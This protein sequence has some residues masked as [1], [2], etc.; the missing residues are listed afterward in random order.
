MNKNS[1]HHPHPFLAALDHDLFD[2]SLRST[3]NNGS[4]CVSFPNLNYRL[5]PLTCYLQF[6]P[7]SR[8]P[9]CTR[10]LPLR[11][12]SSSSNG[13]VAL[14]RGFLFDKPHQRANC[15]F[16]INPFASRLLSFLVIQLR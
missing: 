16:G 13:K 9:Y 12:R 5:H 2:R 3:V 1:D 10:V 7:Q 8:R 15:L 6:P 4:I 11:T 14:R